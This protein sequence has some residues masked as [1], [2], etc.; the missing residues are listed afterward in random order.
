MSARRPRSVPASAAVTLA[1]TVVFALTA[2][3]CSSDD[4]GSGADR[5]TTSAPS[6]TSVRADAAYAKRG[7][8]Q[9]G[10]T[11]FA[12]ADGRPVV[13]WYPAAEDAAD[14]PKETFDI[15]SLLSPALQ[16]KIPADKRPQYEIDAHPGAAPATGGPYPLV[17]FSHGFAAF[18]E[19]SADLVTHLASWGFVVVAPSHVERSLDVLLG[20]AAQGVTPRTD[21]KVLQATLDK[22]PAEAGRA[23][24]PLPGPG[25]DQKA[26]EPGRS[27][28]AGAAYRVAG[29][30]DGI[31]SFIPC[32]V[33]IG[34]GDATQTPAKPAV[35]KVPGMVMRG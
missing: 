12:L 27:A 24:A 14:A 11:R 9:V 5:S 20:T 18:P 10:T 22:T 34:A 31:T 13:A 6:T 3:A 8:D 23:G 19:Q 2:A 33:G 7:P 26:A 32:S 29:S 25:E 1:L 15:A 28:G 16:S 17:L 4:D 35:H 30:D 21:D